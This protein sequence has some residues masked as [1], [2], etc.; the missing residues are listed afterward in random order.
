MSLKETI[1]VSE[2]VHLIMEFHLSISYAIVSE[3]FPWI[4]AS[5]KT[6][7]LQ[8]EVVHTPLK[9]FTDNCYPH[10]GEEA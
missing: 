8:L 10:G 6:S 4:S 9:H 1:S 2:E 3:V 7:N 5:N